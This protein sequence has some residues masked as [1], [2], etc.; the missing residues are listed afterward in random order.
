MAME[1]VM[2]VDVAVMGG[3]PF[4]HPLPPKMSTIILITLSDKVIVLRKKKYYY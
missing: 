1:V 4:F 3:V 2:E